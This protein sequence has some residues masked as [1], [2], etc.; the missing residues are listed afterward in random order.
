MGSGDKT[1]IQLLGT[2]KSP[3]EGSL[4]V[5]E[6]YVTKWLEIDSLRMRVAA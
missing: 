3:Y 2:G 4:D 1:E 5:S 6:D